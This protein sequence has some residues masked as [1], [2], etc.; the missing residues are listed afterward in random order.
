LGN[1]SWKSFN[2]KRGC[3]DQDNSHFCCP[4]SLLFSFLNSLDV[5]KV[6]EIARLK[7][8][9]VDDNPIQWLFEPEKRCQ[10]DLKGLD[11]KEIKKPD[12]QKDK[13]Y[14]S[15]TPPEKEMKSQ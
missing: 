2:F 7:E 12:G 11:V 15:I 6:E 14:Y 10:E 8:A 13:I 9:G 5:L 4:F 1:S 3:C